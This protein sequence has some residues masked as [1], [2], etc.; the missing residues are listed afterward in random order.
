MKRPVK[1]KG[2]ASGG[3]VDL[4]PGSEETGVRAPRQDR[5]A[6]DRPNPFVIQNPTK[7][8]PTVDWLPTPIPKPPPGGGFDNTWKTKPMAKGGKVRKVLRKR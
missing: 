6:G 4:E 7:D 1:R 5:I 8:R 3:K 2:Y